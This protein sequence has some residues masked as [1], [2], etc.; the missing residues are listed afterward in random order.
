MRLAFAY[1]SLFMA[2]LLAAL[3]S[4]IIAVSAAQ[5]RLVEDDWGGWTH[6]RAA[7]IA[8][9]DARGECVEIAGICRS[10]CTMYLG[11]KCVCVHRDAKVKFHGPSLYGL[12]LSPD[13]AR[14]AAE[15]MAQFYPPSVARWYMKHGR[16]K[17]WGYSTITGENLIALGVPEC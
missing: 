8:E 6:K 4:L 16:H 13:Y 10:A 1:L 7:Q 14:R 17:L 15:G 5:A 12:P 11:L 2:I 3:V 9:M